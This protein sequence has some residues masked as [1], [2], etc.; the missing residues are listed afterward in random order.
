LWKGDQNYLTD[1]ND[2]VTGKD[3]DES[4]EEEGSK[5]LSR[6]P[7][8]LL[9]AVETDPSD[10]LPHY[11]MARFNRI[12]TDR[13]EEKKALNAAQFHFENLNPMELKDPLLLRAR[14][15]TLT[16]IGEV[17]WREGE[18]ASAERTF[19]DAQ[20]RF[21]DGLN[22]GILQDYDP[23]MGKIFS[24]LGNMY[25][26]QSKDWQQSLEYF[27]KAKELGFQPPQDQFRRGAIYYNTGRYKDSSEL[28]H[29][30][31]LEHDLLETNP[32]LIWAL[33]NSLLMD[34]A[35]GAAEGYFKILE[36]QLRARREALEEVILE[37]REDHRGLM[38]FLV[39]TRTNLGVSIFR[40]RAQGNLDNPAAGEVFA[41]FTEAET[42]SDALSREQSALLPMDGSSAQLPRLNLRNM[43]ATDSV[44]DDIAPF[45]DLPLDLEQI[46]F[47]PHA[48]GTNPFIG[49]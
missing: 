44:L 3:M 6:L 2:Q 46:R 45:P 38:E 23:L 7:D 1:R 12:A 41:L 28:F 36:A 39:K 33:G 49:Y 18:T 9:R 21:E 14:I 31:W 40:G 24:N 19:F 32:N 8:I 17:F 22:R 48:E 47:L 27:L 16:R 37:R 13:R 20:R 29:A 4:L 10:P 5:Y 34:K 30:L 11:Q 15:D 35:Y 43:S 42:I 26:Y 25:Y